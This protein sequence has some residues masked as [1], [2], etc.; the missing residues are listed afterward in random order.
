METRSHAS[1]KAK[2]I[3]DFWKNRRWLPSDAPLH[4]HQLDI[5]KLEE[6]IQ[7][8]LETKQGD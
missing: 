8:A 4:L 1:Q 6:L 5:V 7:E 2:Q 3:V